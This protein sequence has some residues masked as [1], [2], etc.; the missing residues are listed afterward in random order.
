M[1]VCMY[2]CNNYL[3][4]CFRYTRLYLVLMGVSVLVRPTGA[5]MWPPVVL[6][7]FFMDRR[8]IVH[9]LKDT[10]GVG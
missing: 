7:Q 3:I 8:H 9:V 2:V 4:L 1:Y 10:I 5:I 6:T